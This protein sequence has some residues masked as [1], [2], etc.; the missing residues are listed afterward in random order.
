MKAVVYDRF[1]PPEVMRMTELPNPCPSAGEV[2]VR[3]HATA[4]NPMD[5]VFRSGAPKGRM[6]SGVL[7]PKHAVLGT[8]AAGEVS[9]V[10]EGVHNLLVGDRVAG[11][12]GFDAGGYAEYVNMTASE[13][14]TLPDE[15]SYSDASALTFAGLSSLRFLRLTEGLDP[16]RRLLVIGAS[17]GLGTFAVQLAHYY[18]AHVTGVCSTR[19]V[20]LVESLGADEVIDYTVTD[21]TIMRDA[22]DVIFDAVAAGSFHAYA[23]TLR[24][25]GVYSTTV[26]TPAI[27]AAIALN[28]L[29]R[30]ARRAHTAIP[31]GD[32]RE[33]LETLRDLVYKGSVRP[34]IERQFPLDEVVEAHHLYETGR[35]RGKIILTL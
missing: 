1:G 7:H 21:P 11:I 27:L 25:G 18:G 24:P 32:P 9:E 15:I 33:D 30:S 2:T 6:F 17:G 16:G 28:P 4:V 12:T 19:N 13:L 22:Y 8:D 29:R 3:V 10:G 23:K 5:V 14:V 35:T 20:E 26:V 31:A 34:V